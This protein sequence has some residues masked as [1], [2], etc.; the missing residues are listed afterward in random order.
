MSTAESKVRFGLSKVFYAIDTVAADGTN[1]W[2]VPVAMTNAQS[3]SLDR[4]VNSTPVYA[5][6]SLI[7]VIKS[8]TGANIT[9]QFSALTD[10]T[11]QALL[12]F[13]ADSKSHNVEVTNL[14]PAYFALILQVEGDTKARRRVFLKC[15]ASLGSESSQTVGENV[16][17]NGDTLNISVYPVEDASGNKI[18]GYDVD[19]DDTDYAA[20][21]TAAPALPTFA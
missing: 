2:A 10:A 1:S 13:K 18:L 9:V 11:K 17:V 7:Y 14:V 21:I 4:T 6:N 5:D 3:F 12:G 20:V 8:E 15:T 16:T 19:S